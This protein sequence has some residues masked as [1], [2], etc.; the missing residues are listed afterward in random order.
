[1]SFL[2][3]LGLLAL[4][5]LPIILLLHLMRERRRRVVVPSLLIWQL[6]PQR[7]DSQRRRRLPVTLLLL[8]QLLAA[9][10][11]AFALAQ[12][13]W[14]AQLFVGEQ[15]I[16]VIVDTSTSMAATVGG[17]SR[18]DA[19]RARVR[20]L[21]GELGPGDTLTLVTAGPQPALIGTANQEQAASLL[22][23]LNTQRATGTGS[24]MPGALCSLK[25]RS[26]GDVTGGSWC[27]AMARCQRCRAIWVSV[28][29]RCRSTGSGSAARSTTGRSWRFRHASAAA[30]AVRRPTFMPVLPTSAAHRLPP[31]CGFWRWTA[32]R[33]AQR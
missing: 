29:A 5:S 18:L 28:S 7:Q 8:L 16:A 1:M 21:V 15:H 32:A 33:Y 23:A 27:G 6:L 31:M 17:Q 22:A 3:P 2:A 13:A 30:T 25:P 20:G 10:L 9:A 12:P 4:V 26:T 19:A 24:D 11:L 14:I